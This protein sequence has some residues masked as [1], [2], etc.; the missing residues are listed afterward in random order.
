MYSVVPDMGTRKDGA[1]ARDVTRESR[2]GIEEIDQGH[3][4][5]QEQDQ[6]WSLNWRE[7]RNGA[8]DRKRRMTGNRN[9][10]QC[11]GSG[12]GIRRLFDPWIRD[13]MGK[14]TGYGSGM[15]NPDYISEILETNFLG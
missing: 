3:Y 5:E 4:H 8:G 11:C 13:G 15:N 7:R 9:M 2:K 10:H 14:K 12:A 1:R 6:N